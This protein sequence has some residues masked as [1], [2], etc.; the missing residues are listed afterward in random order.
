MEGVR[1]APRKSIVMDDS[2][3]GRKECPQSD[4]WLLQAI[5]MAARKH[6]AG[7]AEVIGRGDAIEHAIFKY[8]E[9]EPGLARMTAAGYVIEDGGSFCL[10]PEFLPTYSR[11]AKCARSWVGINK[12]LVD[13]IRAGSGGGPTSHP[14]SLSREDYY[15][16]VRQY[17]EPPSVLVRLRGLFKPR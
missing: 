15:D 10:S 16:A 8:E 1:V 3:S 9:I 13:Y 5:A 7:L 2:D 17:T 4:A 12:S 14:Y 6:P 11:L